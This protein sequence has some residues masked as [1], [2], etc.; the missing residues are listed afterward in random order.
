MSK[1]EKEQKKVEQQEV[2]ENIGEV[3][4]ESR[5]CP[6]GTLY[7]I[8]R[9]DTF[10]ELARRF[11]TTV[12]A[13]VAANPGVNPNNLQVGQ[14]ICIPGTGGGGTPQP[15][16]CPGGFLYTIRSGDTFFLLAQRFGTTVEAIRRANPGVDPN[17]LQIGQ[18]I[19]IPV[20]GPGPTPSCPGGFLYT[21]RSGD[22]F[23][24]L[25][26]RFGTTV[27]AIRRAN[28]GVDP[29][30]LQIG[31]V[32]CIPVPGPG[33]TPPVCP[34][35]FLYSIRSGDTFFLLAQR[36]GTTVEAI[37][38]ANPGVDPNNLQI[39]QVI[40]IPVPGPT[41][42]P[43]CRGFFYTIRPGDTYFLLAQRFGTT[44][45]ALIA[46]NPGVDPNNLQVGQV[47][48]IP[49]PGSVPCPGGTLYTIRAGDTLFS[50][51]QRFGI[52]VQAILNANPGLDPNNL[53]IGQVICIPAPTPVPCLGGTLYTVRPGDTLFSIAQR[54][55]TTVNAIIAANPGIDPNNLIPGQVICIPVPPPVPCP[56][57]FLYTVRA[58][59]TIFSIAQR[60]GTTVNAI[61]AAN[62]GIDPNNLQV[63]QIIC[64]PQ[65]GPVPCPGGTLYTIRPGDT[66]F[67]IAQRFGTTVNA[68][69]AANPGI[70]PN[71]L[72]PGQVICVPVPGPVPCPGGTLY[73]VRP[74]DTLFS[75][76]Q[77]FGTT[78][79]A[80]IAANPGIDPNN[81]QI[82]QVICIPA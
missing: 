74:G 73:T 2:K 58:G 16:S 9:G 38:R 70:D 23:F 3:K 60:F 22:T 65:P 6:G 39:G 78:V 17:N 20:S 81:L 82:G 14:V 34:G 42:P 18:V 54:F 31:Q 19:C 27:E 15:G 50:I 55:G 41:P 33:P 75:I 10:F 11:G 72:I 59:D 61:I 56:N 77:R 8:R 52:T 4:Q 45:E 30:N 37:M 1:T 40:C 80:I 47:I 5:S 28:P 57:G 25:A 24:L 66:L 32:I 44:V 21:I 76:A 29:N 26:Q 68:I 36:F 63:G 67:N 49:V 69:I 51:A 64:V 62:P 35:G 48:C 12:N 7:T 43:I 53:Q 46:A 71:N 79:N 13:I